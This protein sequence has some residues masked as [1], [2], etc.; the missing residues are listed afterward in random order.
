MNPFV[1]FTKWIF[2]WI[3]IVIA[4]LLAIVLVWVSV[5][6]S[7][8]WFSHQ[9]HADKIKIAVI[10]KG[11]P[12]LPS[13]LVA[14]DKP[15]E[16]LCTGDYPI[17]VGFTNG[18]ERTVEYIWINISAR[19][20]ERSTNILRYDSHVT[21]DRIVPPGK[22]FGNCARFEVEEPFNSDPKLEA[23]IYTGEVYNVRFA[24]K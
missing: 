16:D 15:V 1:V 11:T 9:R 2:K 19:L 7:W 8:D 20:P 4:G 22:G 13:K 6:W 3:G 10:N 24:D 14:G 12:T 23:A 5:A 21:M 18:S 17:F